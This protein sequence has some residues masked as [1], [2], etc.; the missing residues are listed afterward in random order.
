MRLV[1]VLAEVPPHPVGEIIVE[2]AR[3]RLLVALS[4]GNKIIEDQIALDLEFARQF[5]YANL[6]HLIRLPQNPAS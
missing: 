6:R 2:S 5:V 3:V 4:Y 1:A